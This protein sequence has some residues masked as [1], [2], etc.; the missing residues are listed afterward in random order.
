MTSTVL[1]KVFNTGNDGIRKI[2]KYYLG[3]LAPGEE[4][5]HNNLTLSGAECARGRFIILWK[6]QQLHG[7]EGVLPRSDVFHR[8]FSATALAN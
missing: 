3:I 1:K 5:N 2:N 6:S 4:K 7:V 8:V